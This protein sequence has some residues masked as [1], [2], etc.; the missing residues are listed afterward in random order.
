M[1]SRSASAVVESEAESPD[2]RLLS[3]GARM[4]G[5]Q[6]FD[7][8]RVMIAEGH[9]ARDAIFQFADVSRPF[10]L[11]ETF[12]R[13]GRD[14]NIFSGGVAIKEIVRELRDV[15]AAFAQARDVDGYDVETEIE[16]LAKSSGAVGGFEIAIGGGDHADVHRNFFIAADR[17]HFFFLQDAQELGLHF[18]RKLA[19]FIEKNCAAVGC[20]EEAGFGFQRAGEGAF[21]VAEEFAFHQRGNERAAIHGDEGHFRERAA[22]VNGARDEFL[23][24]AAFA[25][26]QHGGAGFFQARDH[27]QDVLNFG[28]GADDA[29]EIGDGVD[30]LAQELI[31]GDEANFFGHA[32]EELAQA[33][34]AKRL[35]DVIVG[36]LAHGVH[37]G[38]DGTVAGHDGDFGARQ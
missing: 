5:G 7:V 16:I 4:A 22:K 37:G 14:L 21:L 30:A 31:F 36:A 27:A 17:T 11:Q 32:L 35:F 26:D 34:D 20:L 25:G 8:N 9:G 15:G 29:V 28:G 1:R 10:V 18:Q 12:H 6:I 24:G 2:A 3:C 19:D 33:F 38:F 23:A 13:R